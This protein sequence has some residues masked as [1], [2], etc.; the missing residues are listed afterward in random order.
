[1]RI[2]AAEVRRL[3]GLAR[4]RVEDDDLARLADELSAVLTHLDQLARVT[5]AAPE[6]GTSGPVEAGR[7]DEPTPSLDPQVVASLPA[8]WRP[9]Y[10]LAPPSPVLGRDAG[11]GR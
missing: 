9:P 10:L 6:P 5:P 4:L 11:N 7:A 2:D 3:A 1:M 8:R